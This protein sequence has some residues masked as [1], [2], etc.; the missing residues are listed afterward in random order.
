MTT[1]EFFEELSQKHIEDGM[2]NYIRMDLLEKAFIEEVNDVIS[3]L[4]YR[5]DEFLEYEYIYCDALQYIADIPFPLFL[6][7]TP[8]TIEEVKSSILD[9][10]CTQAKL[11]AKQRAMDDLYDDDPRP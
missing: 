11:V 3:T 4:S 8:H 2:R 9:Y 5:F 7:E 1:S 6:C 10:I